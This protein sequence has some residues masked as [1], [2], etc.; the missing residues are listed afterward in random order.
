M[1]RPG[2]S[3][4]NGKRPTGRNETREVA[5][6]LEYQ[7]DRAGAPR[8][9]AAGFG[10]IARR[11]LEI[12]RHEGIHIHEDDTLAR[13]LARVPPGSEIPEAAYQLVAELLAFLY[14]TD[15]RL[16]EKMARARRQKMP[17][18]STHP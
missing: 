18:E 8:V 12:A 4:V 5:V 9:L 15:A 6:A 11:I 10:E 1:G 3:G 7:P 2:A 13:L 17:P 16:A 14:A